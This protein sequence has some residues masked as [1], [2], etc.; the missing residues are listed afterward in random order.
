MAK[1][2]PSEPQNHPHEPANALGNMYKTLSEFKLA[3]V[4]KIGYDSNI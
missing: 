2:I 4:D 3:F 1:Q